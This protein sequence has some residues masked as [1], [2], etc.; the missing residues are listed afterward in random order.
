M[1]HRLLTIDPDNEPLWVQLD[2]YPVDNVWAAMFV[3]D[4]VE[5][6]QPGELKGTGFFG[7]TPV[8]AQELALRYLTG[9]VE[10]NGGSAAVAAEGTARSGR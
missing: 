5:P 9:C 1:M 4:D 10:Q 6:A 3:A 2:V 7:D 8:E